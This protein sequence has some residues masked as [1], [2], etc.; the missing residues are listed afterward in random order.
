MVH[1]PARPSLGT[2]CQLFVEHEFRRRSSETRAYLPFNQPYHQLLLRHI[3]SLFNTF[4]TQQSWTMKSTSPRK[5]C[6]ASHP[7]SS[8]NSRSSYRASSRRTRSQRVRIPPSIPKHR[9]QNFLDFTLLFSVLLEPQ[10]GKILT[11][12]NTLANTD[13]HSLA[14]ICFKKCITSS[15]TQ[16]KLAGKE[17]TCMAN[18]VNRWYDSNLQILKHLD[19]LRASQ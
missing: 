15:I 14:E 3:K 10:L 9:A 12:T 8:E 19:A 13:T 2:A 17:E 16:G 4:H 6:S 18:C 5:I 11:I 7:T 1:P